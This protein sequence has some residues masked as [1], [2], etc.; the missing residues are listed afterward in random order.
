MG[1][2]SLPVQSLQQPSVLDCASKASIIFDSLGEK[3]KNLIRRIVFQE[4]GV[5]FEEVKN[6]IVNKLEGEVLEIGN[7]SSHKRIVLENFG[8]LIGTVSVNAKQQDKGKEK[9]KNEVGR[10]QRTC[11]SVPYDMPPSTTSD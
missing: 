8:T 4:K 5:K 3:S 10:H 6:L 2:S 7:G 11:L 9:K 1:S